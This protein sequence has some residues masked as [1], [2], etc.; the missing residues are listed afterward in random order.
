MVKGIIFDFDGTIVD[1]EISRLK[2]LNIVLEDYGY[3]ITDE[4]WNLNYRRLRSVDI[5]ED[6]KKRKGFDYDS[7]NLYEKSHEIRNEIEMMG[8][9][10]VEGF[11]EFYDFLKKNNIKMMI[12]S[13]GRREHI[14]MIMAVENLPQIDIIGREDYDNVKPAPDCYKLAL[15][16][17]NLKADEV[18][19]FDDS[20]T[21]LEAGISAGC[22]VIA[23]NSFDDGIDNL[24]VYKKVKNYNELDFDEILRL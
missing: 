2:S 9:R 16:K 10:V 20:V 15:K 8:V 6:I 22:M 3:K 18:V 14:R 7:Y 4:A 21:G 24:D 19:V 17:M 5:L 13:G 11:R 23:I 12:A 1:S